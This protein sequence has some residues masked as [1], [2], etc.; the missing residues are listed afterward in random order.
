MKLERALEIRDVLTEKYLFAN[1]GQ[2]AYAGDSEYQATS[3]DPRLYELFQVIHGIGIAQAPHGG[4]LLKLFY[5]GFLLFPEAIAGYFDIVR[6]DT[7]YVETQPFIFHAPTR[8]PL[9]IGASISHIDNEHWGSLGCFVIDQQGEKH[10]LSCYHVLYHEG[11]GYE[12]EFILQPAR[13]EGGTRRDSVG[14]LGK[15]LALNPYTEN[16]YDAALAGPLIAEIDLRLGQSPDSPLLTNS[17][18]PRQGSQVYKWGA[19]TKQTFGIVSADRLN[20]KITHLGVEYAF[21]EQVAIRGTDA[22]FEA[23]DIFSRPGDSGA[24]VVQYVDNHAVALLIAG[25]PSGISLAT[26]LP[27]VLQEL[28]VKLLALQP[29]KR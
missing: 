28:E 27:G 23:E 24:I 1:V 29:R 15:T 2:P 3:G 13:A 7:E 20:T 25:S 18:D 8:T 5:D 10:L 16:L 9:E 17:S 12:L 4:Y 26:P 22:Q 6:E 11:G 21:R 14:I 19:A